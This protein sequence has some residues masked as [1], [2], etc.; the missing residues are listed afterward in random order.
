MNV[1]AVGLPQKIYSRG[2]LFKVDLIILFKGFSDIE[3][4]IRLLIFIICNSFIDEFK[5]KTVFSFL[6]LKLKLQLYKKHK[7]IVQLK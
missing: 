1:S 3:A 4:N 2:S 7:N 6:L 5:I